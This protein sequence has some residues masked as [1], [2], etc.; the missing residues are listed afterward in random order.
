MKKIA[1]IIMITF[2]FFGFGQIINNKCISCVDNKVNIK[3]GASAVGTENMATGINSFAAGYKNEAQ[4]DYSVAMTYQARAIGARSLSVGYR[5]EASGAGSLALGPYAE[6][7]EDANLSIA[8][9]S[10]VHSSALFSHTIGFGDSDQPL[11]NNMEKSLMIGYNSDLPTLFVSQSDGVGTTGSVGIGNITDPQ[12]KLHIRADNS[13]YASL[14]LEPTSSNKFGKL[15]IGDQSNYIQAKAQNNMVFHTSSGHNFIF[16][17]GNVG[18]GTNT[19]SAKLDVNGTMEVNGDASFAQDLTIEGESHLN[20]IVLNDDADITGADQIVGF[21]DLRLSGDNDGGTDL[22]ITGDGNI[23]IGTNTPNSKLEVAGT[24]CVGNSSHYHAA[25]IGGS[26]DGGNMGWSTGYIGFNVKREAQDN[27]VTQHGTNN[28]GASIIYGN[29]FGDIVFSSIGTTGNTNQTLTDAEIKAKANMVMQNNGILKVKE[30]KVKT[31]IWSDYVFYED[32][33]LRPLE[34]V[35]AYVKK[36]KHLPEVPSEKE[37]V[38]DGIMLGQT[39]VLLLKKIEE[40]TLY[41]IEQQKQ[42]DKLKSELDKLSR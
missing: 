4:G 6:T 5:S 23:G 42:I 16:G 15:M 3:K 26:S 41:T 32:Y 22:F 12:A 2:P 1:I 27:W 14:F 40:L 36:N 19:P 28:N 11:V 9:G 38:E 8:I 17:N 34:D 13:E 31:N 25:Y 39:N 18:I 35:E 37:V 30:V 7:G 29:V 24:F 10:H 20:G 33:K 21:N